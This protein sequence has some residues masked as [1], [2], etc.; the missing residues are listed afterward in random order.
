MVQTSLRYIFLKHCLIE[1]VTAIHVSDSPAI[2]FQRILLQFNLKASACE[3]DSLSGK[4]NYN[5]HCA[6][7]I[8]DSDPNL[9]LGFTLAKRELS[10]LFF[11]DC[12]RL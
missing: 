1:T 6:C 11:S 7:L 2:L 5:S 9:F 8:L 12:G 3:L 10:Q 4:R